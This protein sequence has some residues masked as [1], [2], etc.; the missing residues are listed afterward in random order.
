[1]GAKQSTKLSCHELYM[2]GRRKC[3]QVVASHG[4]CIFIC[5]F[6]AA[7]FICS[8]AASEGCGAVEEGGAGGR[9]EIGESGQCRGGGKFKWPN[10]DVHI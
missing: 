5:V 1:M 3:H 2:G 4:G 6:H 10:A 7:L 9:R 8:L